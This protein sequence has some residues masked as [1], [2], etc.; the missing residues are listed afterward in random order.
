MPSRSTASRAARNAGSVLRLTAACRVV[1]CGS[2]RARRP[3]NRQ[4]VR[5]GGRRWMLWRMSVAMRVASMALAT[6][7]RRCLMACAPWVHVGEDCLLRRVPRSE[8]GPS[9]KCGR[10]SSTR[11]TAATSLR[12]TP[13]GSSRRWRLTSRCFPRSWTIWPSRAAATYGD[14]DPDEVSTELTTQAFLLAKVADDAGRDAWSRGLTIG[15][16]R[17]DVRRLLEHALHD[18]LH[19]LGDVERGLSRL[20]E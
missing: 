11:P 17:S 6:T 7:M 5:S 14:A 12:C 10:R 15:D 3:L 20:R 8:C 2:R 13:T 18:S 19:H 1:L 9:P 16:A 4:S